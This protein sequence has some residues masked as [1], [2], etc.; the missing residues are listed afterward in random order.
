MPTKIHISNVEWETLHVGNSKTAVGRGKENVGQVF[1]ATRPGKCV[2]VDQMISTQVGFI[3]QLKGSLTKKRYKCATIFVDHYSR[4][5]YM[6]LMTSLTSKETI[7]AKRS[8]EQFAEQ[9]GVRIEHYHC[10][11]GH[12]ADNDFK[13]ACEMSQQRLT[14]CGIN[15]HFQ[16]GIAKKEANSRIFFIVNQY[17]Y[18]NNN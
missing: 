5:Q 2:S 7:E 8:F 12:F 16:N 10:D 9:H 4:L 18:L 6:H 11:N 1:V 13:A 3:A 15:A 17:N 14:F